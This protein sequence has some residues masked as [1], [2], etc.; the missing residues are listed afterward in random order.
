MTDSPHTVLKFPPQLRTVPKDDCQGEVRTVSLRSPV[1]DQI[2]RSVGI[3]PAEWWVEQGKAMHKQALKDID[4]NG[5]RALVREV[6]LQ[7]LEEY[8][9]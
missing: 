9:I 8:Q 7:A 6:L 5:G 1:M 3:D 4:A 2:F